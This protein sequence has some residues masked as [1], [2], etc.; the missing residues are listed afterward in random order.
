MRDG[1]SGPST[2]ATTATDDAPQIRIGITLLSDFDTSS[3]ASGGLLSR[4]A[5]AM[6]GL[7][8]YVLFAQ[9]ETDAS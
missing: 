8:L 3:G 1:T 9:R 2:Q 4:H 6:S 7:E 5:L